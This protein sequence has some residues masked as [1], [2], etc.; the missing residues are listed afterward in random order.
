M[1]AVDTPLP[2][3]L[4]EPVVACVEEGHAH[5]SAAAQLRVSVK[6]ENDMTAL[7]RE[8]GEHGKLGHPRD[9]IK[10]RMPA[11]SSQTENATTS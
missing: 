7:K 2:L 3:E 9:W 5:L 4:R 10:A 11:T 1:S 6:F 8:T